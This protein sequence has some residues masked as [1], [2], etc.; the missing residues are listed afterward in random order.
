MSI[1]LHRAN[2]SNQVLPKR[3]MRNRNLVPEVNEF[4]IYG[5]YGEKMMKILLY[6]TGFK[7]E[8]H[9]SC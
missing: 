6:G 4:D 3:K 1:Y 2:F 5:Y 9:I 7:T 8:L